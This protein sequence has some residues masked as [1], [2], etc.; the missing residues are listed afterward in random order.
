VL[1][2]CGLS[3]GWES[4][5]L[6][7]RVSF[8]LGEGEALAVL[9]PNGAGKSTLL[10][11]LAG[12]LEPLEGSV[13]LAGRPAG[14]MPAH[15]RARRVALV[16]QGLDPRMPFTVRET[17]T[18][19][20]YAHLR[21]RWEG[22]EDR[23]AVAQAIGTMR[24]DGVADRPLARLSGGERQ[25]AIIASALAQRAPVLLLDEPT[26]ALDL[27]ARCETTELLDRL[28]GREGLAVVLV[29]HDLDLACR[30]CGRALLLGP[31]ADPVEGPAAEVMTPE[32]LE[33]AFGVEVRVLDVP[34]DAIR[35]HVPVLARPRPGGGEPG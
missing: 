18:M 3:F 33:A 29:T 12:L 35:V 1:A 2:A 23:E 9:G 34:G 17:V 11:I 27:R 13:R 30:T 16:P 20:R 7:E 21:G 26:T 28:R 14:S 8:V 5:R 19:G 25:R 10:S 15:E 22:P 4:K 24:L 32:R 31:G 6:F